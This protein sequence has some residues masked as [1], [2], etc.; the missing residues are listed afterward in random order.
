MSRS[1]PSKP[2]AIRSA[3]LEIAWNGQTIGVDEVGRGPLA[4]PVV[5]AAVCLPVDNSIAGLRD[6]KKLSA[7][8]R[9]ELDSQ[10]RDQAIC[11]HIGSASPREID[12]LNILQATHLAMQRAVAG[13]VGYGSEILVDGNRLPELPLPARAIVGGDDR[14]A[15]IS[16]AS[17]LA[18]QFR[19]AL[20][21]DLAKQFPQYGFER[22]KGYGTAQHLKALALLGPCSWHRRSFS[23]VRAA[24]R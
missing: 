12:E 6:S 21:I 14:V 7:K 8:R 17:I 10:I 5:A 15:P 22:H 19:D 9:A 24:L 11:W 13:V 4:G 2:G 16:A 3:A 23:P 18:K 1:R 20:M